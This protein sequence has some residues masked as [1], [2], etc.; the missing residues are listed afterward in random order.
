MAAS[1]AL[2]HQINLM[3]VAHCSLMY[4]AKVYQAPSGCWTP[5]CAFKELTDKHCTLE[6]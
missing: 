6:S 4:S 3:D 5:V 1:L 2:Q